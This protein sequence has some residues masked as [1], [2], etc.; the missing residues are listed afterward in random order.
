M[1]VLFIIGTSITVQADNRD[2]DIYFW[3]NGFYFYTARFGNPHNWAWLV[4]DSSYQQL[5]GTITIPETVTTTITVNGEPTEM[6][7]NVCLINASAFKNCTQITKVNLPSCLTNIYENAFEGCTGLTSID[8]PETLKYI[9]GNAFS[10]CTGIGSITIPENV[11][12]IGNYAF[13]DMEVSTVVWNAIDCPWGGNLSGPTIT[14]VTIGD[15]VQQLPTAFAA[16]SNITSIDLPLS[17][18]RLNGY[19]FRNCKELTE[20]TIPDSVTYIGI[21]A[22]QGNNINQLTWNAI[23]CENASNMSTS[24]VTEVFVGDQVEYIPADFIRSSKVQSV[25]LPNSVKTIGAYAFGYCSRLKDIHLSE[26]L[27]TIGDWTFCG[28]DSLEVI[29]IPNSVTRIGEYAFYFMKSLTRADL[30]PRLESIG[31]AA[32]MGNFRITSFGTIPKTLTDIGLVAFNYMPN[33]QSIVVEQGNPVY[34]SRNNCNALIETA[35]NT[36]VAGSRSTVIPNTVKT[37]GYKAFNR[38]GIDSI[39]LPEGIEVIEESGFD[40][41]SL[42]FITLPSTL[43]RIG[44]WAFYYNITLYS[45]TSLALEPPI[46][47]NEHAFYPCIR[48]GSILYVPEQSY[49]A[50]KE[51]EYWKD[52]QFIIPI[53]HEILRGDMNQD[54]KLG[55]D[56]LTELI[57]FILAYN[58]THQYFQNPFADVDNNGWYG[59]S[60]IT[61]LVDAIVL[62]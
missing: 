25:D 24:N 56:D 13:S 7:Y 30:P 6:T 2:D 14:D 44:S 47:D 18:K 46:I 1:A 36:L 42:D 53:G 4:P 5:S 41:C 48:N 61:A 52:F 11:T 10:G 9:G 58:A 19:V 35:T 26:N 60:D 38:L 54:G 62:Q 17:L 3:S 45:V 28:W 16:E 39:A 59:I 32:Y 37:I 15:K 34:D 51:A 49:Q 22:F 12:Y 27:E 55:I 43:K 57:D 31:E 23:H 20:V 29:N 33:L 50:Y 8:F 21:G 40:D